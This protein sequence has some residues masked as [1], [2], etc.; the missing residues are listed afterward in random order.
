MTLDEPKLGIQA[1]ATEILALDQALGMLEELNE[2]LSRLVELRFFAGLTVA[3]TAELMGISERTVKRDW[4]K[5]KAVLH[6]YLA[7][8]GAR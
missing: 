2:R 3:E 7:A 6:G 1:E 5:A 8:E 4:R